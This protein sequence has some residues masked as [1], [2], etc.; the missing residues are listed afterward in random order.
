MAWCLGTR[1]VSSGNA[2]LTSSFSDVLNW[3]R[4]WWLL[5]SALK[6][7]Q[8]VNVLVRVHEDRHGVSST[9]QIPS[10]CRIVLKNPIASSLHSPSHSS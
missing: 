2:N 4:E 5:S 6:L 10:N 9:L 7:V 1:E 3:H 8:L